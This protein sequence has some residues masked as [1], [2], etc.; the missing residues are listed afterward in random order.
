MFFKPVHMKTRSMEMLC[1]QNNKLFK[2]LNFT[3]IDQIGERLFKPFTNDKEK[4]C[5]YIISKHHDSVI[6]LLVRHPLHVATHLSPGT[7]C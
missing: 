2:T 1:I 3:V 4:C 7:C 6:I 5:S